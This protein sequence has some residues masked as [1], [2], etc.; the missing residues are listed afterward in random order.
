M[1]GL[2]LTDPLPEHC[3]IVYLQ[4]C[5]DLV[6]AEGLLNSAGLREVHLIGTTRIG[7]STV[8]RLRSQGVKV[9]IQPW[10]EEEL[11]PPVDLWSLRL[12]SPTTARQERPA[13]QPVETKP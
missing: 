5:R 7:R 2:D 8:D 10:L 4:D 11:S 13:P 6:G 1:V 9:D 12:R 3:A